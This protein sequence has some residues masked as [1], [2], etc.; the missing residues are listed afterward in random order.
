MLPFA[1]S[2]SSSTPIAPTLRKLPPFSKK[3]NSWCCSK[4]E[5]WLV[6]STPKFAP[7][8]VTSGYWPSIHYA[9]APVSALA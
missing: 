7:N 1:P 8:A 5:C 4:M 6:A 2:V 3:G 9:S